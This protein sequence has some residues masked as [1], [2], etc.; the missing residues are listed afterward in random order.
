MV[1]NLPCWRTGSLLF[2]SGTLEQRPVKLDCMVEVSF[3]FPSAGIIISSPS[4]MTDFV[5]WDRLLL[6][7]LYI[8]N[9]LWYQTGSRKNNK[10]VYFQ[11]SC[12]IIMLCVFVPVI[13][14][15]STLN[16]DIVFVI[17]C[18]SDVPYREYGTQK[19]FVKSLT[20]YLNVQPG[21]SRV[22]L[23]TYG[24]RA[25]PVVQFDDSRT[26]I[27]FFSELTR[28]P[29]LGG[30][31]RV[32]TALGIAMRIFGNARENVPKVVLLFM[33]GRQSRVTGALPLRDSVRQLHQQGVGTF[34]FRIGSQPE[35]R[36]LHS[37]V[38]R[39]ENVISFSSF[40]AMDARVPYVARHIPFYSGKLTVLMVA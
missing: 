17:D 38:D 37:A 4:S 18:S 19:A 7:G 14:G 36:E 20:K 15:I 40:A 35:I 11:F 26:I 10:V 22:A 3:F 34:I 25:M 8:I 23:V 9:R 1:E 29:Y 32:D 13:T 5:P 21:H 12:C 2:P 27:R 39:P 6:K 28:A 16:A 24:S 31:R 30:G 33:A